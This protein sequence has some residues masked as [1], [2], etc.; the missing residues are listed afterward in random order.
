MIRETTDRR[1]L[2][3]SLRESCEALVAPTGKRYASHSRNGSRNLFHA[4]SRAAALGWHR[5]SRSPSF[6]CAS[7]ALHLSSRA[8]KS[9]DMIRSIPEIAFAAR[10]HRI[11]SDIGRKS[12]ASG[13]LPAASGQRM[14]RTE[15]KGECMNKLLATLAAL[16]ACTLFTAMPASAQTATQPMGASPRIERAMGQIQTRFATANTTHDGKLT[17]AQA[18]SGMPMVAKHFDEIDTQKNGYVTLPQIEAFM[19]EHAASH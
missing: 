6:I 1:R 19:K 16:G 2:P 12:G 3:G 7:F 13:N 5:T 15:R 17:R 10:A 14:K 8:L 4:M 11:A 18:S 9:G